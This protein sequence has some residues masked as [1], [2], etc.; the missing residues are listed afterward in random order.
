MLPVIVLVGMGIFEIVFFFAKE[1]ES[2]EMLDI[3]RLLADGRKKE[4]YEEREQNDLVKV[5][6]VLCCC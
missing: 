3:T 6:I 2:P 1:D 4:P 5:W